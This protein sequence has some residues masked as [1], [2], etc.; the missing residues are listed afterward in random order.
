MRTSVINSQIVLILRL[1]CD[2]QRIYEQI[3]FCKTSLCIKVN[4]IFLHKLTGLVQNLHKATINPPTKKKLNLWDF[5][6]L[7]N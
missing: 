2:D 4:C 3:T 5:L 1:I 7:Y 6:F